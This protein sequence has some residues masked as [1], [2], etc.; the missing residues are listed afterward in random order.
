MKKLDLDKLQAC[1][2][3]LQSVSM[4]MTGTEFNELSDRLKKIEGILN[5]LLFERLRMAKDVQEAM[6]EADERS[7]NG[8]K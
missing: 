8:D 5:D 1:L 7:K 6:K 4:I 3:H 2:W